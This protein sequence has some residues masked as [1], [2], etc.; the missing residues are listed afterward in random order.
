[1]NLTDYTATELLEQ[2][3]SKAITPKEI[4]QSC[5]QRIREIDPQVNAWEYFDEEAI[6]AQLTK[7]GG[8]AQEDYPLYG[9]PIGVKD[10]YNTFD[11]PTQMGSPLWRDFTPGN[12][13]RLIHYLRRS[14][15]IMLGK[16]VT[17][18]F[19]VHYQDKTRNPHDLARSPGTSSSGSAVA[20]ATGMVPL[21]LGSQTAGSIGRPASY[22]G[23][24]GFK[25]TFGVLPR[26]GVLKTTDSLDTLGFF[27]RSVEDLSLMFEASRVHGENY[28][29][30]HRYIDHYS[31]NP[32]KIYRIGIVKHPRWEEASP[33]A[34]EQFAQWC[35][36]IKDPRLK[37]EEVTL[38]PFCDTIHATHQCIYDKSL[39][40]YFKDEYAN[41]ELMSPIFYNIIQEGLTIS[42]EQYQEALEKQSRETREF[43]TWMDS[44]DLLITLATADEAP[45]GLTT[46]DIPDSNLIWTYLGLPIITVP[47][48]QGSNG[49]PIGINLIARKY[50]DKTLLE[51]ASLLEK[52]NIIR[53]TISITPKLEGLIPN[54]R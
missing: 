25:P 36:R 47:A 38:P 45:I 1:M 27:S 9:I 46:P 35:E 14:G 37:F 53:K 12:D 52:I 21:A 39:A 15:A 44:Y 20:V 54:E 4:A 7:I 40:Y 3:R 42:K 16:T 22:C 6:E 19:A 28:E 13:A 49:L 11:M 10:I 50:H 33:Y 30:V 32:D 43:D 17:A 5:I 34:K 48:L 23:I 29:F 51:F 31:P 18:E 26:I 24:Y 2:L 8:Y 41:H